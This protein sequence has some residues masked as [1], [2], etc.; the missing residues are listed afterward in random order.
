M[1]ALLRLGALLVILW[2]LLSGLLEPLY[3][4]LG[5]VSVALALWLAARMAVADREGVPSALG[6]RAFGYWPWL[7]KEIALANW[8]VTR[9]ILSP[10]LP[11][12]PSA[13]KVK[14]SQRTALGRTIYANSI[15]LTPGTVSMSIDGDEIL[16]HALTEDGRDSVIEGT[17]DRKAAWFEGNKE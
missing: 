6:W 7:A 10:S 11:I 13:F 9:R 3:L 17:M 5:A 14:A 2:L 8:D 1:V 15:T 16:V 4:I 12:S